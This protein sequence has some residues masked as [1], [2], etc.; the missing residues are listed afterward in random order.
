MDR[1][2]SLSNTLSQMTLYDIRSM[3]TQAKNVVLNISETEAKVREAT[4]DDPWGAS[5]SLMQ[6][7]AQGTF[8]FPQFNEIMPCIYS[9]FMEKEARQWRQIYKALQLLE[10]LIKHGSERVVDD[11][12]AH[13]STLKMLR[14]FHYIDDKGK[15]EGVNVRNR[16]RELV[17]LLSDVEKIRTERKKAKANRHKY[18]GTGNDGFGSSSQSGGSR[19]GGFGSDSQSYNNDYYR[20]GVGSSSGG[21]RDDARRSGFEE[22][23]AGDDEDATKPSTA[24]P[25]TRPST[26][27]TISPEPGPTSKPAPVADLLGELD[28]DT[29]T[30]TA[31]TS[32]VSKPPTNKPP[33]AVNTIQVAGFDDDDFAD[34]QAAP[35]QTLTSTGGAV[36]SAPAKP[37]LMDLL[38]APPNQ[39]TSSSVG[40]AQSFAQQ[41]SLFGSSGV[42]GVATP[43]TTLHRPSPSLSA[44]SSPFVP[45]VQVT[46]SGNSFGG[47]PL[48]SSAPPHSTSVASSSKPNP[49]QS[50]SGSSNF[51]DLWSM[52]LGSSSK[53]GTPKVGAKSIKD[54]EKEKAQ[55]A[56]WG[57]QTK[58]KS[59]M[60]NNNAFGSFGNPGFGSGTQ[61]S[62]G[63]DDLLL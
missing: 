8:N 55:A 2:E 17:E 54:L 47:A 4:N 41:P 13:I 57:S 59:P 28:D 24:R 44:M 18:I 63:N 10:Y 33:P 12:R 37:N 61:S 51:D 22:Y 46:Q 50:K 14:N 56:L 6:E 21:F 9:R 5:S 25:S 32:K 27:K 31:T 49:T 19:Y 36:P 34:F 45:Q 38:N 1:L 58:S 39:P 40:F 20:S 26:N 11:A 52:S 48:T 62:G 42:G 43:S 3:Y 15:D 35:V 30:N 7:I 53:P 16:A 60:G 29:F 23:D